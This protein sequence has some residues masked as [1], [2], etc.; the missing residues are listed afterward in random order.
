[1]GEQ[2]VPGIEMFRKKFEDF[3]KLKGEIGQ[4]KALEKMFEGYPERQRKN[5]GQFIEQYPGRGFQ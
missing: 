1:M 5:M 3:K 2:R 4:E